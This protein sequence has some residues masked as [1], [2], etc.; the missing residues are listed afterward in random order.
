ERRFTGARV[1]SIFQ[2]LW[3]ALRK[4]KRRGGEN[5]AA[6]EADMHDEEQDLRITEESE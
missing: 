2:N 1:P 4:R 5:T 3:L 6:F